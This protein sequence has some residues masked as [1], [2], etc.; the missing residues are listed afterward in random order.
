M[1]DQIRKPG[2]DI[3]QVFEGV[4]PTPVT[5]NLVPCIVG[6]AYE[7]VD[8][9]DAT[10]VASS[11]SQVTNGAGAVKYQQLPVTI[12]PSEYP[13][14]RADSSQMSILPSEVTVGIN[15]PANPS[16]TLDLL[17]RS[18]GTAFLGDVNVATMAGI[19]VSDEHLTEHA[20]RATVLIFIVDSALS[21]NAQAQ[22]FE[23]AAGT[24]DAYLTAVLDSIDGIG[25]KEHTHNG[26]PGRV[27]HSLRYGAA[28]SISMVSQSAGSTSGFFTDHSA[29]TIALGAGLDL[30]ALNAESGVLTLTVTD[31]GALSVSL[32][33]NDITVTV[34]AGTTTT[35]AVADALNNDAAISARL[36]LVDVTNGAL[37]DIAAAAQANFVA[38]ASQDLAIG[39]VTVTKVRTEG[40]GFRAKDNPV[41]GK[42][43]S[44]YVEHTTG[45]FEYVTDVSVPQTDNGEF[46]QIKS[47]QLTLPADS[48]NVEETHNVS[49]VDFLNSEYVRAASPT[50]NG[51]LFSASGPYGQAFSRVMVTE[52]TSDYIKLGVVDTQRSEYDAEGN[53]VN[54][55]YLDFQVNELSHA[56]PFAP[57]NGYF[58]AQNLTEFNDGVTGL[59][60]VASHVGAAVA[61]TEKTNAQTT[62]TLNDTWANSVGGLTSLPFA[63][64]LT[65]PS[66]QTT[67]TL[68]I[69][70]DADAGTAGQ[71]LTAITGGAVTVSISAANPAVMT[72]DTSSK[73]KGVELVVDDLPGGG[74]FV[75]AVGNSAVTVRS[76]AD[77]ELPITGKQIKIS[78]NKGPRV[79]TFT[80]TSDSLPELVTVVNNGLGY[81]GLS[82]EQDVANP[83]FT[84]ESYLYGVGSSVEIHLNDPS[85]QASRLAP[86]LGFTDGAASPNEVVTGTNLAG[87]RRPNPDV[88]VAED[89]TVQLGGDIMRSAITGTPLD[90]GAGADI[91][92]AYRALRLD[93]SPV[94]NQPGILRVSNVD[95]LTSV[96]GPVSNRN[97]LALA[98]YYAMINMGDG[99]EINAIGVSSVSDSE[100]DG[101]TLAY[102]EA[103]EFLRSYEVYSIVP[104]TQ[105]EDV[106]AQFDAHVTSMSDPAQ[107]AER[108][109]IASPLNPT[110]RN[111]YV[112]L[113]TGDL[114]AESTGSDDQVELN[115][116]PESVLIGLGVNT[117]EA[118]PFELDN[119]QQ[120]YLQV[121][122]GNDSYRYSVSRISGARATVKLTYTSAQNADGFY[123]TSPISTDYP[124]GFSGASFSLALR[125]TKLLLPGAGERLDKTAFSQ[126]IRDKAQQYLNRRQVRLFPD[127]VQSSAIG[128][129]NQRLPSYYYAAALAGAVAS[130]D[131]QEPL[132]RV[133]M[134]GFNDSVGP[135]LERSHL[136][137]ISAGNAVIEVEVSGQAPA[138]RMQGTTDPSTIESREW[139]VTRAVD[140]F[141]KTMRGQLKARIG[142][143]NITQAYMDEL[144]LLVDS[145]CATAVANGQFQGAN[146]VK[147]EQDP[148]Q[149]DTILVEVQL[150]VLYPAN[151][152]TV[153]LV[154]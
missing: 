152:I 129:I 92:I 126:T 41:A 133:P 48:P 143:F 29:S 104:L 106:I 37:T 139:S 28:G 146:V 38:P 120:L 51:D 86:V 110:R 121:M 68:T 25:I 85:A 43:T 119:G 65:T 16:S 140:A 95:D 35:Q 2:V 49:A 67:Y 125:G 33:G 60:T 94:A 137:M 150:E 76:G 11:E 112:V 123:S 134:V 124:D 56:T 24:L 72:F 77:D 18:P 113:S 17:D 63:V 44:A 91:H 89:G 75:A 117:S 13:T 64:Q 122:I 26:A 83:K 71:T 22:V 8:M 42:L 128:G 34:D 5:A 79:F 131:A 81:D 132:T 135:E 78:L 153:T 127:T 39:N 97:P 82:Y 14:P 40:S 116:N 136:D 148:K 36:T 1:V 108:A 96:Y 105:S 23:P 53:P 151:Y 101:T 103:A 102:K 7:V 6:P 62:I 4:T 59:S 154:V 47:M 98:M 52:V 73:G 144:T 93:L 21:D 30:Y 9:L 57:K 54:Q 107:R 66:G 20:G 90:S 70:D 114:G 74:G 27:F 15:R 10:G 45:A 149:P 130:L 142:R 32:A 100:P 118:I 69:P 19:W 12:L 88:Y 87:T 84:L 147:L 50:S 115:D 99:V 46:T 80:A 111:D 109:V 3:T 55:R 58:V 141:S 145:L 31:T 138:L 61:I